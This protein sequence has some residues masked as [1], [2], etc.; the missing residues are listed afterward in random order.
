M[1]YYTTIHDLSHERLFPFYDARG[2]RAFVSTSY[3]FNSEST[4]SLPREEKNIEFSLKY[5]L[6]SIVD[7]NSPK[8][9][10]RGR[11]VLRSK[12]RY[13]TTYNIIGCNITTIRSFNM[14]II[15]YLLTAFVFPNMLHYSLYSDICSLTRTI[16][17]P[18]PCVGAPYTCFRRLKL[19]P[20]IHNFLTLRSEKYQI[21]VK[22]PLRIESSRKSTKMKI[23]RKECSPLNRTLF[24][25]I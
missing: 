17:F 22:I 3:N 18:L 11:N 25:C 14:F 8:W 4:T 21:F 20:R 10:S 6:E 2:P 16:L 15:G 12:E 7:Q 9:K 19:H 1:I 13:F 23:P 5:P 24:H